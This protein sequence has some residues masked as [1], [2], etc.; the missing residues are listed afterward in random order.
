VSIRYDA[1]DTKIGSF[2]VKN[3]I[4]LNVK[5]IGCENAVRIRGV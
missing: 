5:E 4:K 3:N 2:G 1:P